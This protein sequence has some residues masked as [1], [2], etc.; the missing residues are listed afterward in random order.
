MRQ[1]LE[2]AI[3]TFYIL[4]H[5]WDKKYTSIG[6]WKDT[7]QNV[8]GV[9]CREIWLFFCC[10]VL[11]SIFKANMYHFCF[12]GNTVNDILGRNEEYTKIQSYNFSFF[13]LL[14]YQE[15]KWL[16]LSWHGDTSIIPATRDG[17][18]TV[19]ISRLAWITEQDLTWKQKRPM[20]GKRKCLGDSLIIKIFVK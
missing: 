20:C 1:G 18:R 7:Q 13:W 16:S 15:S 10:L 4:F 5:G 19:P 3:C 9:D 14:N 6:A 2:E 12:W 11:L 8:S 17:G